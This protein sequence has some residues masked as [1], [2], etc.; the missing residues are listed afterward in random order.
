[1]KKKAAISALTLGL[2]V[3]TLF[4]VNAQEPASADSRCG[5]PTL[6]GALAD[7]TSKTAGF[8]YKYALTTNGSVYGMCSPYYG[9]ASG[10]GYFSGRTA[11]HLFVCSDANYYPLGYMIYATSGETY[12]YGRVSGC[13]HWEN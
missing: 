8:T 13:Y 6:N 9:G 11:N 4:I 10:Q 3:S 12:S 5:N 1:M 2:L 7:V